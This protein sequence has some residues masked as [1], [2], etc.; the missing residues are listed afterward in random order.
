MGIAVVR[1]L[2]LVRQAASAEELERFE[3]DVLAGFVLAR[4][5]AGLADG[6]IRGDLSNLDQVRSWFGRPLWE[7]EPP[8]ADVYFGRVLRGVPSGTRLARAAALSVYFEFLELRH[9][10]ELHAM[11]GRVV[12]CPIDEMNRPRGRKDA[13]IRIPPQREEVEALFA[14]WAREL[15]T[16]R[17]FAPTARN[18]TAARLMADVGLRINE[19]RHL[20]FD[21]IH[22]ELGYFGKLHVRIG[23][24]ANGSGPR[25]RMVPLLNGADR[26]LR[27]YVEDVWGH[28][29]DDHTRAG[30]PLLPSERVSG[31]GSRGRVGYNALRRGLAEA[32]AAYLPGWV[33]RMSPHVLRHF[34]ASQLYLNGVDLIS[35]QEM[36]GHAWVATTM[37]YVHVHRSRIEEAWLAGQRRA[38]ARLEGLM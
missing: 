9:K 14:G 30:A 2:R 25:A 36:Y 22:W 11:T 8:D 1:D 24:G 3:T 33:G 5:S 6:T 7:M 32:T 23:K 19:A 20:D 4:S 21:D 31:N 12:E 28:F 35:I 38:T 18:Y 13:R 29:G 10:V 17:K 15:A 26:T 34:C 16:C 27:W 37:K